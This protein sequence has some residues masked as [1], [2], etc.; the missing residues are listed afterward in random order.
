MSKK[1]ARNLFIFG[2]AFFF[3]IL[4]WLTFDSMKQIDTKHSPPITDAVDRG[5]M[6]WHKYDCIGCHT[7]LGNGS[8]FAPDMTKIAEKKPL[9]YL[10]KWLKDPKAVNPSATMPKLGLK[11]EEIDDLLA[12]LSWIAKVD[13]NGW[14]PKPILAVSAAAGTGAGTPGQL[15]YQKNNCS[16]CHNMSGIGGTTGPELTHVGSKRDRK[17]LVEHFIDPE[18]KV[19]GSVMPSYKHLSKQ[20]LDDLADYLLSLK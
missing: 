2:T 10:K 8:Y 6:V 1:G 15:I 5:K 7:I 9:G 17:W 4:I 20:E 12:M 3:I 14:P 16:A 19:S 11:D 13:T 18:K